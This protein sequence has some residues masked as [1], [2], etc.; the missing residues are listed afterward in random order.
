MENLLRGT[1][2]NRFKGQV[3]H[4]GHHEL[5]GRVVPQDQVVLLALQDRHVLQGHREGGLNFRFLGGLAISLACLI[6]NK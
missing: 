4:Q 6:M 3:G 5:L 2:K 1:Q